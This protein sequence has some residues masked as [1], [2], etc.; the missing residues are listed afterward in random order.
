M[1]LLSSMFSSLLTLT[2]GIKDAKRLVRDQNVDLIAV[3]EELDSE[4]RG[5]L[6][7]EDVRLCPIL[8]FNLI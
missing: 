3:F 5:Y 7:K 8:C 2:R 1:G 6:T 4:K